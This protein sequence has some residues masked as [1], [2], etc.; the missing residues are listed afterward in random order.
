VKALRNAECSRTN[1]STQAGREV[2]VFMG[3]SQGGHGVAAAFPSA[4]F[5]GVDGTVCSSFDAL[6]CR[7]EGEEEDA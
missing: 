7:A 3:E 1:S 5:D 2:T 6:V 4:R